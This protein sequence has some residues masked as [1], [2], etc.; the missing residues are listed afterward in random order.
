MLQPAGGARSSHTSHD[1]SC[2]ETSCVMD[3]DEAGTC[4]APVRIIY[5]FIADMLRGFV[6]LLE[7]RKI[8]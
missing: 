3:A 5:D 7:K 2:T 8:T 1:S 4:L 6:F